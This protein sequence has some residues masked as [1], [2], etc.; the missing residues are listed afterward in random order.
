MKISKLR[1]VGE[2]L[3]RE[4]VS[5]LAKVFIDECNGSYKGVME[6]SG[7]LSVLAKMATFDEY[8]NEQVVRGEQKALYKIESILNNACKEV[9]K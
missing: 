9:M 8:W 7:K 5:K 3:G 1:E 6:L 4:G 2:L